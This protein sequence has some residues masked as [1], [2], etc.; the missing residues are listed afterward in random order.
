[1][2][3]LAGGGGLELF[4]KENALVFLL[5][6]GRRFARPINMTVGETHRRRVVSIHADRILQFRLGDDS[7]VATWTKIAQDGADLPPA[8]Q[9]MQAANIQMGPG[10]TADFNYVP[11]RPGTFALEVWTWPTGTRVIVPII[12][13]PRGA[14]ATK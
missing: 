5:V 3:G 13:S 7:T 1:M 6:N 8:L 4:N 14:V 2:A 9:V 11:G 12:V 10:E